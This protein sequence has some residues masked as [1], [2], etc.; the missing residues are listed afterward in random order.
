MRFFWYIW[1]F[2]YFF[3]GKSLD[4]NEIQQRNSELIVLNEKTI[5]KA[6]FDTSSL[7]LENHVLYILDLTE[8][9]EYIEQISSLLD[10]IQ[11]FSLKLEVIRDVLVNKKDK[12]IVLEEKYNEILS[13]NDKI[14]PNLLHLQFLKL[15]FPPNPKIPS[16]ESPSQKPSFKEAHQN[17]LPYQEPLKKT[18]LSTLFLRFQMLK[19]QKPLKKFILK[20]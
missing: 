20:N 10:E 5:K 7:I 4:F 6:L 18:S 9:T 2:F 17:E 8:K 14:D 19:S 13:K 16:K 15:F 12:N 3:K 11:A 1:L